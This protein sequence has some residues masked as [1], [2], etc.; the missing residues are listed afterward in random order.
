MFHSFSLQLPS[1]IKLPYLCKTAR[2]KTGVIR[3]DHR[4]EYNLLHAHVE[5]LPQHVHFGSH[6]R[7]VVRTTVQ[8]WIAIV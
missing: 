2:Y 7:R 3:A 6:L 1:I 5:V 8:R 4:V